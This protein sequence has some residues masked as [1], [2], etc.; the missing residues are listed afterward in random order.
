MIEL[1]KDMRFQQLRLRENMLKILSMSNIQSFEIESPILGR[2]GHQRVKASINYMLLKALSV[3]GQTISSAT[4]G[5]GK[6]SMSWI[7]RL[8][9]EGIY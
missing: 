5:A 1:L 7:T 3:V 6:I 8:Q 9:F 4:T 2:I